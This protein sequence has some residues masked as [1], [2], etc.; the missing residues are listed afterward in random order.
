MAHAETRLRI[1]RGQWRTLWLESFLSRNQSQKPLTAKFAEGRQRTQRISLQESVC[2]RIFSLKSRTKK[3][4]SHE[5]CR[6]KKH[7]PPRVHNL[8]RTSTSDR[9]KVAIS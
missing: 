2:R 4:F 1:L 6:R 3:T 5:C 9:A 8:D 7:Q